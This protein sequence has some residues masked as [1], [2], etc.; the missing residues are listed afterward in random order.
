MA[1]LNPVV[2]TFVRS[3]WDLS[4]RDE[5]VKLLAP[6]LTHQNVVLDMTGVTYA[7][8]TVLNVLVNVQQER[9]RHELGYSRIVPSRQMRRLLNLS[10]L[11]AIWR[12]HDSVDAARSDAQ[13]TVAASEEFQR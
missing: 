4:S 1:D 3:E 6:A 10:G 9:M 7:D 12:L 5:L 13:V 2:V 8:S 11:S